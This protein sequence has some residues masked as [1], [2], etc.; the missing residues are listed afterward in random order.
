MIPK[1]DQLINSIGDTMEL[2]SDPENSSIF[3]DGADTLT[4]SV[5]RVAWRANKLEQSQSRNAAISVYGPSQV[6]KSFL[7]SVLVRPDEGYLKINFPGSAGSKTYIDEIN[8]G[9]DQEC[10]GLVTRFTVNSDHSNKS[11]PVY[12]RL[13]SEVDLL[14]ILINSYF[15]EGDQRREDHKT[16]EQIEEHLRK[17]KPDGSGDDL[18]QEDFWELEEYISEHFSSYEYAR[19]IMPFLEAIGKKAGDCSIENRAQLYAPLWGFHS[20]FTDLFKKLVSALKDLNFSSEVYAKINALI[21][22]STSIID[23]STL[24]GIYSDDDDQITVS[25]PN[26]QITEISRGLLSAI[27]AELVLDIKEMP[28]AFFHHTDVLDFP[29]TRNRMA[30]NLTE[31]FEG[32]TKQESNIYQFLLRGKVA[33]LF[34][35]YVNSQDINSML[36]CIKDS[37]MEAV[38]LPAM[39]DKWVGNTIGSGAIKRREQDNN[40]FFVMTY[41]DKHLVDTAANR[42]EV[43]RFSRRL[44][45]SLL[46]MFGNHQNTWVL[47]WDG[48]EGSP[49]PFN[50]CYLLRNPGVDQ[51]FFSVDSD[52]GVESFVATNDQKDRLREIKDIF[53]ATPEVLSHFEAPEEAWEAV[54]KENDGGT[55]YILEKLEG[56]CKPDT[57]QNQLISL[58]DTLCSE[59]SSQLQE[60]YKPSDT[61]E[62]EELSKAKFKELREQVIYESNIVKNSEFSCFLGDIGASSE[63]LF[64]GLTDNRKIEKSLEKCC[65][66]WTDHL[67]SNSSRLSKKYNITKKSFEFLIHELTDAMKLR[68]LNKKINDSISFLTI[69]GTNVNTRNCAIDI[70]CFHINDFIG[71]RDEIKSDVIEPFDLPQE[72]P[73]LQKQFAVSWLE[74][75][76]QKVVANSMSENGKEFNQIANTALGKILSDLDNQ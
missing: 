40:L 37:N 65:D 13:L 51:S 19:T 34:D 57:K 71:G 14:C 52:S 16:P 33:Y 31:V 3:G 73:N 46:E 5:R 26:G 6:G 55:G 18:K 67:M 53:L 17:V 72:K 25:D 44:K 63:I 70:A 9:G 39:I 36:L 12:L 48:E 61:A 21:P 11:Y 7:A 4:K 22:K 62:R 32:S 69:Q 60:Y 45:S 23:V 43:D 2:L 24:R 42:H 20:E 29:G 28:H 30:V 8:P 27:T 54:M 1:I 59:L 76:E 38:G 49:N 15:C 35:K 41:F 47:N 64:A 10:T 68:N 58:A 66:I 74:G 50:N 56:I 75:I